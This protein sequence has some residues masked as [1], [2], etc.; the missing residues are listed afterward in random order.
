[1]WMGRTTGRYERLKVAVS[2]LMYLLCATSSSGATEA[3][4]ETLFQLPLA[5]AGLTV[6]P[7]GNYLLSVSFGEKPQNRVVEVSRAGQSSP[8][9]T[10]AIS[11][12]APGETLTLDAVEGLQMD[13]EGLVWMLDNGRRSEITP[14]VVA[15]HYAHKRLHRVYNLVPPALISSSVLDDLVLDPEHPFIYISDPASG[16]DAALIVLDTTTGL[17]RRVLQ[18]HPSVVPVAGL[19]LMI[20]GQNLQT[21]R[22]D[23]TVADPDGGIDPIALD[24]KGE[25]LY[26]GPMR[27]QRLYRVRTEFLRN[28]EI[29]ASKLAG[30]VEEYAAKPLCDGITLDSKGNVY[31]SD[32]AGKAIGMISA[33]SKEYSVLVTD[34]RL[35][36]PDGL[37]FGADGR[38]VFYNNSRK[39][40]PTAGPSVA[41]PEVLATNYLFRLQT[42]GSGRVGD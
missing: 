6:T 39:A 3:K 20:D 38:L 11:Q 31:L 24:R 23:G 15:W 28:P 42:P 25:W 26:F 34:P 13:K 33:G 22:L 21:I 7:Q 12:A 27:S 41:S 40:S 35:L 10:P 37:C 16:A 9:P 29:S 4:L 5:P 30:Y 19:E 36:W 14:K 8:F 32:L 17:A 18:G 2:L 1:M